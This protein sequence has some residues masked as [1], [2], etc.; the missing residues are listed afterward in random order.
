MKLASG[1]IQSIPGV[2]DSWTEARMK[3]GRRLGDIPEFISWAADQARASG[4]DTSFLSGDGAA[5]SASRK[6]EIEKV[7]T[8]NIDKYYEDG[9]DKE[10][11]AILEKETKQ[12]K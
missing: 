11:A 10:L 2:G 8:S 4:M 7:M 1:F 5:K 12:K 3:D 9:L 6:A